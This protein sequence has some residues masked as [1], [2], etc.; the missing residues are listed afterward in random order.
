MKPT[1]KQLRAINFI[2]ENLNI[3]FEGSTKQDAWK[4]INEHIEESKNIVRSPEDDPRDSYL[5]I[6]PF[7]EEWCY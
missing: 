2:E 6:E 7:D 4:F 3:Q 5:F 1:E